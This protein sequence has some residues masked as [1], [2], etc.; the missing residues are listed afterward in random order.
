M[1][2]LKNIITTVKRNYR[3]K[4]IQFSRIFK[5]AESGNPQYQNILGLIKFMRL[6]GSDSD[7]NKQAEYWFKL[8][9]E[10][11]NTPTFFSLALL[12][13]E[14]GG[15][16]SY[17]NDN[18]KRMFWLNKGADA[19]CKYSHLWLSLIYLEGYNG[20]CGEIVEKNIENHISHLKKAATHGDALAQYWLALEYFQG[21]TISKNKDLAYQY[22]NL[23]S[24]QGHPRAK[25]RLSHFEENYE[26]VK[27]LID[28]ELM[29][30]DNSNLLKRSSE[31]LNK[32][33]N[34]KEAF[35][36]LKK[37]ADEGCVDAQNDFGCLLND[38]G[39]KE[40]AIFWFE[41]AGKNG[42]S[43]AFRNLAEVDPEK[44]YFHYERGAELGDSVCQEQ[45]ARNYYFGWSVNPSKTKFIYWLTKSAENGRAVA[46]ALLADSYLRGDGV[47]VDLIKSYAWSQLARYNGYTTDF[48][49]ARCHLL[50]QVLDRSDIEE[51]VK[52]ISKVVKSSE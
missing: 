10:R 16:S 24:K 22:F 12:S 8:S 18:T 48:N 49:W 3:R 4:R 38:L 6:E 51:A 33:I 15:L 31:L 21:E 34:N 11:E 27:E 41:Q 50:E 14:H 42:F 39:R 1:N 19:G 17:R 32:D 26:P 43:L 47:N 52:L 20:S 5:E 37:L 2:L 25:Y 23:S 36:I 46:Q 44:M 9:A 28:N 7:S 13:W 45:H 30:T 40:D 29:D 35:E